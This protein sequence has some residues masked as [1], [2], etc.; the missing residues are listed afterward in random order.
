MIRII[1]TILFCVFG[2]AYAQQYTDIFGKQ[3]FKDTIKLSKYHDATGDSCLAV[4]A[5][6]KIIQRVRGSGGGGGSQWTNN[7]NDIYNNNSGNVGIGT[8]EPSRKLE[9]QGAIGASSYWLNS[10]NVI[11]GDNSYTEILPNNIS[12]GLVWFN[13]GFYLAGW[14]GQTLIN[15]TSSGMQYYDYSGQ[16]VMT[17][18]NSSLGIGTDNPYAKLHVFSSDSN[19]VR[20]EAPLATGQSGEKILS[21]GD[22]GNIHATS[23]NFFAPTYWTGAPIAEGNSITAGAGASDANHQ[24][25]NLMSTALGIDITNNAISGSSIRNVIYRNFQFLPTKNVVN[26]ESIMI[27]IND[28][29]HGPT[30]QKYNKLAE[31]LNVVFANSFLNTFT[32]ITDGTITQAG[33]WIDLS[34]YVGSLSSKSYI[35]GLGHPIAST[36]AG[37]T[38]S[39]S[40]I[41][42]N[43]VVGTYGLEAHYDYGRWTVTVDGVVKGTYNPNGKADDW[44]YSPIQTFAPLMPNDFVLTGLG[45]GTHD[46]VITMLDNKEADFDYIGTLN[47]PSNCPPIVV[48]HVCKANDAGYALDGGYATDATIDSANARIDSIIAVW[49]N[50]GYSIG[51]AHTENYFNK[52]TDLSNDGLHPNDNGHYHIARAFLSVINKFPAPPVIAQTL[53]DVMG[54]GN[55]A[56]NTLDMVG[57]DIV[58]A[59]NINSTGRTG[60]GIIS[61]ENPLHIK[62]SDNEQFKL[63]G[64]NTA[65]YTQMDYK[66]DARQWQ[67]GVGNSGENFFNVSGKY[68]IYDYNSTA[69][70]MVVDGSG[71][72]GIGTTTPDSLLT[73]NGGIRFNGYPSHDATDSMV[74]VKTNGALGYRAIPTISTSGF[75]PYTG[76]TTTLDMGVNAVNAQAFKVNG[77]NGAGHIDLK[78]QNGTPPTIGNSSALFANTIGTLSYVN[79]NGT[80]TLADSATVAGKQPQL[81][82]TGFVKFTGTTPSYDNSTYTPTSR[83]ISTTAPLQGGGDLSAN[84]TLSIDTGRNTAQVTTGYDLNKV[85]DSLQTNINGKLSTAVTS[86]ATGLGLTGGTITTTGILLVDT[87]SASIISRQRAAATYVPITGQTADS[88]YSGTVTWTG[89]TP[90]NTPTIS[91][92]RVSKSNSLCTVQIV[93]KYTNAATLVSQLTLDLPSTAPTPY[94]WGLGTSTNTIYSSQ[95]TWDVGTSVNPTTPSQSTATLRKSASGYEIRCNAVTALNANF[96][97]ITIS[98]F[99]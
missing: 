71:N 33:D 35:S 61:P 3:N 63:E 10:T 8:T 53:G 89:T 80:K 5:S 64:T 66:S 92:W 4:D 50:R 91:V 19:A 56:S 13:D 6:G 85:R 11:Q 81:N 95:G 88:T 31:G 14:N 12:D 9:V 41:G 67:T 82:G 98:Y 30:V 68:F 25:V 59:A 83:T 37:S 15:G 96:S 79:A 57:Y 34:P 27:G 73:V 21:I 29:C 51:I 75:V 78:W 99:Y 48:G 62:S 43:L 90:P 86:V 84:R 24:Y 69:M 40:T 2:T 49:S 45:A 55:Q 54:N 22:N 38:L 52:T 65:A 16:Y 28:L 1:I 18:K 87:S 76:A 42:D 72:V 36:T 70:R 47:T 7:G 44:Y 60:I 74:I 39:F 17:L 97:V 93:L 23:Q 94:A 26:P 20:I 32:P 46:V 58:N 77:T